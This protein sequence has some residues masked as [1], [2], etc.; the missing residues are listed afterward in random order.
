MFIPAAGLDA[1]SE[2]ENLE[3]ADESLHP[4]QIGQRKP[5]EDMLQPSQVQRFPERLA[6]ASATPGVQ[7][8]EFE[9]LSQITNLEKNEETFF[10]QALKTYFSG[11]P[12]IYLQVM[13]CV[14]LY[15]LV[16][17]NQLIYYRGYLVLK[18]LKMLS[19]KL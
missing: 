3:A 10:Q 11:N 8:S 5:Q 14:Q 15:S 7:E 1:A 4:S 6:D 19:E 17:R 13:K 16:S 12:E 2:D 18:N 9:D